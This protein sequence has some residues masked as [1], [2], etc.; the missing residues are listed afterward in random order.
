MRTLL[1]VL[2]ALTQAM[3]AAAQISTRLREI[4]VTFDD[5]PL[6]IGRPATIEE[7]EKITTMLVG[8]IT[9]HRIPAVG[10][11]NEDKLREGGQLV[12]RRAGL[13]RQWTGAGLELGTHTFSHPD[14]HQVS[15]EAFRDNIVRGDVVTREIMAE[16]KRKPRFFRHPF[17]HTGRDTVTRREITSFLED[18]GY[19]VAPVT[20][21]NYDY[22]FA[23][24]YDKAI[25]AHDTTLQRRVR[26]EYLGYMDRILSYYEQQSIALLG[27][28]I[29]HV[30]LLHANTLNSRTFDALASAYE[31]RG[32]RF[33]ALDYALQDPAYS[34]PDNYVGDAG[35]TWIHRWALTQGRRGSAFAGEPVVPKWVEAAAA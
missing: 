17:L 25:A 18:K 6:V 21:D 7:H 27:R 23:R 22:I 3:P 5:L 1:V 33:V 4:A 15:A 10:F 11:V 8:A 9:R 2:L 32:Y 20:I 16:T 29:P 19:R 24:A 30:L 28:N 13:L 12:P 14:L 26:D 34:L 35:I 31:K